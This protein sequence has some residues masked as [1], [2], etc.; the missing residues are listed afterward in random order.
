MFFSR[1]TGAEK[2]KFTQKL[3]DRVQKLL[4]NVTLLWGMGGGG[5]GGG[6]T[7]G[8]TML[9][10]VLKGKPLKIFLSRTTIPKKL[11][12]IDASCRIEFFIKSWPPGIGRVHNKENHSYM[13]LF[14][15]KMANTTQVS[16]VAPVSHMLPNNSGGSTQSPQHLSKLLSPKP[17]ISTP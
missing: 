1:T 4:F 7:I 6:A 14:E 13:C 5:R 2:L 9:I 3:H 17:L 12:F 8:K 10:C 16:D 11:K 15:E